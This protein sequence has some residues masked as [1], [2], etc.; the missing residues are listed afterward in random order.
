MVP[1][2]HVQKQ[3]GLSLASYIRARRLYLAA[4][5]LRFTQKSILDISVEYQ[6]DNQQTFS[7]CFKKHFAESPSV[8]RHARKQDF[9][10]LVRSLAASQP[11][12]IQVERVS[13]ARGQYAFHGKQY[14]YHLDI[15][16]LDK[17][18]LPQRS[19]LRGQFYT[20]LGE[21]PTQ[22]YSFTQLVPDG[23]R[24]RVD[25]T[26]GVTTEYPLREG[27]VLEPLP[28]IHGEFCRFRYSGKPVA[29]NDHIIQIYTQV[30]PE[31]GLARGDGPDI[32]VF[33]YSLSGKE[34]L[35]LELQHLVPVV[36]LH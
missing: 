22:T 15:E 11:G 21:R 14:A 10:N 9:S 24:V 7:R 29:L 28:E 27:V 30:L 31:M 19:A 20:L 6:F 33:S 26:L 18:H 25:Y 2:A 5:A 32:T 35:H 23:E 12:D 8:Y 16:K 4:F 13:I 17:S 3:T 1:A 34:E 36:P